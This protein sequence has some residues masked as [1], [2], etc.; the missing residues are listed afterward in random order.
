MGAP[1][2]NKQLI[3][4]RIEA[5]NA[6]DA[7]TVGRL[8]HTDFFDHDARQGADRHRIE[9]LDIVAEDDRVVVRARLDGDGDVSSEIHI[10]RL[11]NGL[12][13]EHWCAGGAQSPR[14]PEPGEGPAAPAA[15]P[16]RGEG[17]P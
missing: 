7:E 15:R 6:G 11:A 1:E 8:T 2:E 10:W 9:P 17:R 5:Q 12:V 13:V 3:L 4:R 14:L 16:A